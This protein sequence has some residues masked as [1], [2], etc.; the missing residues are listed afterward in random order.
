[1]VILWNDT[2]LRCVTQQINN[3]NLFNF[4]VKNGGLPVGVT[5]RGFFKGLSLTHHLHKF[6]PWQWKHTVGL[7]EERKAASLSS[8]MNTRYNNLC[9]R[10]K[11]AKFDIRADE[12]PGNHQGHEAIYITR[13]GQKNWIKVNREAR[14]Q[15]HKIRLKKTN[16]KP[17]PGP[18]RTT[19]LSPDPD[20]ISQEMIWDHYWVLFI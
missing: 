10:D 2:T 16:T 11:A 17:N 20:I 8:T 12:T 7:V 3:C 15:E 6:P 18:N 9:F 4:S 14:K 1:M 19:K 13:Q 5:A